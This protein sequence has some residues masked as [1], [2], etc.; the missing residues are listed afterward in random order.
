[1]LWSPTGTGRVFVLGRGKTHEV[2]R[3][4]GDGAIEAVRTVRE[5]VDERGEWLVQTDETRESPRP[6][7]MGYP[8]PR[9]SLPAIAMRPGSLRTSW[10]EEA[11]PC[12]FPGWASGLPLPVALPR[13]TLTII[14]ARG[15]VFLRP[16]GVD[17]GPSAG[18]GRRRG[19]ACPQHCLARP[20]AGAG[21]RA[22][23]LDAG[24]AGPA[25]I[26]R[27]RCAIN[28][29][30][31]GGRAD[32]G[33]RLGFEGRRCGGGWNAPTG[34]GGPGRAGRCRRTGAAAD[35]R[36]RCCLTGARDHPP[37]AAP[38]TPSGAPDWS[39]RDAEVAEAFECPMRPIA[40]MLSV[41]QGKSEFSP[42][43]E[44]EREVLVLCR[45]CSRFTRGRRR[46]RPEWWP[47]CW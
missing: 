27:C 2:W 38:V 37:P 26:G 25:V 42:A 9:I 29:L 32:A 6:L 16:L 13:Q 19:A 21:H 23:H 5:T 39:W 47:R 46:R 10:S 30:P 34:N 24:D 28:P 40:E 35:A 14:G 18:D 41:A 8:F 44:L 43:M 31:G 15:G 3:L 4:D 45:C 17:Q 20:G 36:S 1:M 7:P 11:S 12:R 22:A 33:A